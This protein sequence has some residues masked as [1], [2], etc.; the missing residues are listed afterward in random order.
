MYG[1]RDLISIMI[2]VEVEKKNNENAIN[3]IRRFTRQVRESGVLK[4]V[5]SLRYYERSLSK[6]VKKKDTLKRL[7]KRAY[8]EKM[9]KLG[10]ITPRKSSFKR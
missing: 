2:N 8:R 4:R 10:K 5:R 6:Y 3:L 9:I 7:K 1:P